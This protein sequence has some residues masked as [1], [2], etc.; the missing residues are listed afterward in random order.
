MT[1]ASPVRRQV[2]GD[3]VVVEVYGPLGSSKRTLRA[4]EVVKAEA[5]QAAA[6][7]TIVA[8]SEAGFKQ[9]MDRVSSDVQAATAGAD[10]T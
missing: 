10:A 6:G 3:K 9:L 8:G 1:P 2:R 7:V 4:T 5:P